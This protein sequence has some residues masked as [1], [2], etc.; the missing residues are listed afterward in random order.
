MEREKDF[1]AKYN[2]HKR[3]TFEQ[4]KGIAKMG[5]IL[6]NIAQGR[7]ASNAMEDTARPPQSTLP[8]TNTALNLYSGY[9]FT[10]DT[11]DKF[12]ERCCFLFSVP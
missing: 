1:E 5:D 9:F 8:L 6:N 3:R 11:A 10:K 7:T 2:E 12:P 4:S